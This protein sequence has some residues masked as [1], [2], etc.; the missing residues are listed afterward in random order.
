MKN[1]AFAMVA[2]LFVAC[3]TAK[4]CLN[5]E[6][7]ANKNDPKAQNLERGACPLVVLMVRHA[8]KLAASPDPDLTRAGLERAHELARLLADVELDQIYSTDFLRTRN[9]ALPIAE[10]LGKQIA[11]YD[12]NGLKEFASRLIKNGGRHL[13]VGHSNTTPEM[14]RLLGGI[15]G[16]AID[17]KT[18]YDRLYIVTID[19]RGA[20]HTIVLRF[21]KP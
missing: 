18:E 14:V 3:S 13:V 16:S 20:V 2:L 12:P 19:P 4:P 21:G 5:L 6:T 9:T 11:L 7:T 8:E 17:E 15:P 10:R 1:F